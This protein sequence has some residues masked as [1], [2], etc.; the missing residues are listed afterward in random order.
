MKKKLYEL[1][2][3]EEQVKILYDS[4]AQTLGLK[5]LFD[6]DESEMIQLEDILKRLGEIDLMIQ[7]NKAQNAFIRKAQDGK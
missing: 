3:N 1:S 2:L 5:R 6:G 7:V 4:V